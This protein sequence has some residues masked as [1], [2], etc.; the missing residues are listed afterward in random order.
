MEDIRPFKGV[1]VPVEVYT[2]KEVSWMAK[3]LYIEI[4]SYTDP[5]DSQ[6]SCFKLNKTLAALL[7]IT[8]RQI[9]THIATLV[10]VGWIEKPQYVDG[11]R[12]L[13]SSLGWKSTSRGGGSQLLGGGVEADFHHSNTD[14]IKDKNLEKEDK[15]LTGVSAPFNSFESF[16]MFF[17]VLCKEF[18]EMDYTDILEVL[19]K[20]TKNMWRRRINVIIKDKKAWFR[21]CLANNSEFIPRRGYPN[22]FIP[23]IVFKARLKEIYAKGNLLILEQE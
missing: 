23:T 7:G 18:D 13:R 15:A 5:N 17:S 19:D 9:T 8:P 20:A 2:S 3:I 14:S 10:R 6:R 21:T 1:W 4:A 12:H 22:N 11:K 16:K